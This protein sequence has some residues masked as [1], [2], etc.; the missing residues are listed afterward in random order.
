M[1]L[2][3]V[4][5]ILVF[6]LMFYLENRRSAARTIQLF[7]CKYPD[8]NIPN[9][10]TVYKIIAKFKKCNSVLD[11]N[12]GHSGRPRSIRTQR[13]V[14]RIRRVLNILGNT[15]QST[16]QLSRRTGIHKSTL[17]TI[18]RRDIHFKPYHPLKV[19]H[20]TPNDYQ[21]RIECCRQ[22]ALLFRE[23]ETRR[24]LFFADESTFYTDGTVN[25]KD[26]VIWANERPND[27]V[28]PQNL[29]AERVCVWAAMSN[30]H[31]IGPWFF[32]NTVTGDSYFT[33]LQ[34]YAI[35]QIKAAIGNNFERAYFLQDG[36][37]A[38]RTLRCRNYLQNQFDN[39]TVGLLLTHTFPLDLQI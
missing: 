30:D 11:Q 1:K 18:L 14:Q 33:L 2:V 4:C 36:A 17:H 37:P 5:T 34:Q 6:W 8:A 24:Y 38:H 19:Q 12:K 29:A 13:N 32:P 28:Q 21:L 31:L 25:L 9:V 10:R 39:R 20:L 27:F 15:P 22:L 7:M 23:M 16:R 26:T 3:S 35:P